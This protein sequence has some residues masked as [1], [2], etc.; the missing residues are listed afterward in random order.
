MHVETFYFDPPEPFFSPNLP[1][2]EDGCLEEAVYSVEIEKAGGQIAAWVLDET[3]ESLAHA[4]G[5]NARIVWGF[6]REFG[7]TTPPVNKS[8]LEEAM[9]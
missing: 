1:E 2:S 5:D 9:F 4:V 8:Y 7:S 3:G 6:A